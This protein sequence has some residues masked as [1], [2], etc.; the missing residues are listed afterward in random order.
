M[1]VRIGVTWGWGW[2]IVYVAIFVFQD[3]YLFLIDNKGCKVLAI[4]FSVPFNV[5][6][7]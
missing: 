7:F 4:L 1:L 6:E 3:E 5:L 2:G